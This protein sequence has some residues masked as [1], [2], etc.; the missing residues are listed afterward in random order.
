VWRRQADGSWKVIFDGAPPC[1]AA[2]EAPT[3][4]GS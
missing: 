3:S 2:L 4:A 1:G